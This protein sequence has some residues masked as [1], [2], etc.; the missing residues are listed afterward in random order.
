MDPLNVLEEI[1]L[2]EKEEEIIVR[3]T[4]D[5]DFKF[6]KGVYKEAFRRRI[7]NRIFTDGKKEVPFQIFIEYCNR[8]TDYY[9][10][11]KTLT[12]SEKE[13][14]ANISR[15]SSAEKFEISLKVLLTILTE[16][17]SE[18]EK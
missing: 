18:I 2:L 14:F 12:I 15:F 7:V 17:S 9:S 1:R 5:G 11:K 8:A 10:Q 16:A 13:R 4:S 3:T 6:R